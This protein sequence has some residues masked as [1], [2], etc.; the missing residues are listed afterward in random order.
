MP[1]PIGKLCRSGVAFLFAAGTMT[2]AFAAP[3]PDAGMLIENLPT[4]QSSL[5]A[6]PPVKIEASRT[7]R[8]PSES[9]LRFKVNRIRIEG[10]D[11]YSE[12]ELQPFVKDAMGE[13]VSLAELEKACEQLSGFFHQQG[14]FLADT[15]IPAQDVKDGVVRVIVL[16][17]RYGTIDI[18]NH[19]TLQSASIRRMLRGMKTGQ[20]IK[21]EELE[22][23]LLCLRDIGG[24]RAKAILAPGKEAGSA[25]L[26]VNVENSEPFTGGIYFDNYGNR[27]SGERRTGFNL[28]LDNLSGN[29]DLLHLGGLLAEDGRVK[30]GGF[31]YQ[32]PPDQFGGR[33]GIGYSRLGYSL[34]EEF[35]SLEAKGTAETLNIEQRIVLKRSRSGNRYLRLMYEQKN[36]EDRQ[37]AVRYSVQKQTKVW[38]LGFAGEQV[39]RI[40]G[41]GVT[42]FFF[43]DAYGRLQLDQ[44]AQA[45]DFSGPATAGNYNKIEAKVYRIQHLGQR[46]NLHLSFTGQMANRNLDSSE[47]LYLGGA[48]GVRAYSQGEAGG[49]E[50]YIFSGECRWDLPTPRFQLAAFFD[51]GAVKINVSPWQPEEN[52]RRLQGAGIGLRWNKP[53]D[54]S[55][56]LDYAWKISSDGSESDAADRGRFWLQGMKFF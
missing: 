3:P 52:R 38:S 44:A 17:G 31:F 4:D 46:L 53:E 12:M 5:R 18:Q 29:G 47:R 55:V 15:I 9:T 10:Q 43:T 50:G 25:N 48:T 40:G 14:Y 36:L 11:L 54:F 37:D 42:S 39:D 1:N 32:L 22:R 16:V 13:S 56:Q 6:D 23:T 28:R 7:S 2:V 30:E 20:F 21:K 27:Y 51:T 49:D 8:L 41:G 33:L 35:S 26:I 34:G 19:S 24:I 45:I